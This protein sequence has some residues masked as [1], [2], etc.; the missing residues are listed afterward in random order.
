MEEAGEK[1]AERLV[2]AGE[3]AAERTEEAGEKAAE[4]TVAA[5]E[6]MEGEMDSDDS[7][8]SWT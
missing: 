5:V 8:S 1:V 2:A 4:R 3:E 7:E 6:T